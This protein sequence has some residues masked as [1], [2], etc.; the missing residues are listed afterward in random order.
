[1]AYIKFNQFGHNIQQ[2][3]GEYKTTTN[4]YT[5][6]QKKINIEKGK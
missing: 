2:K 3:E 6:L 4:M 5:P 1:V